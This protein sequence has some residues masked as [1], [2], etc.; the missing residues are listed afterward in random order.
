MRYRQFYES[1]YPWINFNENDSKGRVACALGNAKFQL[2]RP[3]DFWDT[4]ASIFQ[5]SNIQTY[6][7]LHT[8]L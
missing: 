2:D 8:D 5:S 4:E 1:S 3:S 6:R 7:H